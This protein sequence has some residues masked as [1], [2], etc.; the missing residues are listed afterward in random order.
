MA[1]MLFFIQWFEHSFEIWK[2]KEFKSIAIIF[3]C[4]AWPPGHGLLQDGIV[5]TIV[6]YS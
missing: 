2:L 5:S 3:H 6:F 4:S 1:E